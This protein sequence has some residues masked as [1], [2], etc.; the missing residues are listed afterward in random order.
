MPLEPNLFSKL[1]SLIG[2]D[3][4]GVRVYSDISVDLLNGKSI[5]LFKLWYLIYDYF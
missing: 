1:I 3:N 5:D 4:N 2:L